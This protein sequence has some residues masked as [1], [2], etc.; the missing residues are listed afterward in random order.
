MESELKEVNY[1]KL[2]E[3]KSTVIE[4]KTNELKLKIERQPH[5]HKGPSEEQQQPINDNKSNRDIDLDNQIIPMEDVDNETISPILNEVQKDLQEQKE[6]ELHDKPD[7]QLKSMNVNQERL[8][9]KVKEPKNELLDELSGDT[10]IKSEKDDDSDLQSSNNDYEQ[11]GE[12]VEDK[13]KGKVD[14]QTQQ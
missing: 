2:D 6:C 10:N 13:D 3:W 4:E 11:D 8:D 9:N 7:E 1:S 5:Q 14:D 12:E